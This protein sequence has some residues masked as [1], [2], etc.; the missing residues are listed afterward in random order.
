M[1]IE[2]IKNRFIPMSET[3]FYILFALQK[4]RHGYGIMQ[5]VKIL[6]NEKIVLGAGTVYQTISKLE[7]Y[8]LIKATKEE[9]R[10]KNYKITQLGKLILE[11][12]AKRIQCLY[13]IAKEVF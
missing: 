5:Y 12:E 2:K 9:E 10:K 7:K 8:N 1:D 11:E 3:M 4:E 13:E 6:T